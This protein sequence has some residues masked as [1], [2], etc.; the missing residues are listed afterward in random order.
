MIRRLCI[1]PINHLS[2]IPDPLSNLNT[3]NVRFSTQT[4][5]SVAGLIGIAVLNVL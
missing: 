1:N 3:G 4:T 5:E 2:R